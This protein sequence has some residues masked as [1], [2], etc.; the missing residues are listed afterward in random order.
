MQNFNLSLLL[1][2]FLMAF[3][4][5]E[6]DLVDLEEEEGIEDFIGEENFL[7]RDACYAFVYPVGFTM[8]DGSVVTG[9]SEEDINEAFEAWYET[10]D[11]SDREP[12]IILPITVLLDDEREEWTIQD[13]E[14]LERLELICVDE[15]FEDGD[16]EKDCFQFV[17]PIAYTMPDGSTISGNNEEDINDAFRHWY[18]ENGERDAEPILNLPIII[19]FPDRDTPFTI[20]SEED[21]ER[22]REI[23]CDQD[24]D[25]DQDTED[26]HEFVYPITYLMPDGAI[27][28]GDEEFLD[29]AI[30]EWYAMNG[31]HDREPTLVLPV[32]I[33]FIGRDIDIL[34]INTEEDW[35]RVEEICRE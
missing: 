3:S 30:R 8:P 4:A 34:T 35:R 15:E 17:Y 29:N 33:E 7:D 10:N 18:E 31:E 21:W 1:F 16:Q 20:N 26:C 12:Q 2:V 9:E 5:C 23:C 32:D 22:V 14:D 6:G 24:D 27:F 13:R 11:Q 19:I 25:D 28:S